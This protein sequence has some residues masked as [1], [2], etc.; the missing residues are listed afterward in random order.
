MSHASHDLVTLLEQSLQVDCLRAGRTRAKLSPKWVHVPFTIIGQSIDS[1]VQFRT[2]PHGTIVIEKGEGYLLRGGVR[3]FED[4]GHQPAGLFQWAHYRFTLLGDMDLLDFLDLPVRLP[5]P[6]AH[7]VRQLNES[8]CSLLEDQTSP[9]LLRAM[10]RR[11]ICSRMLALVMSL[12]TLSEDPE[13]GLMRL[14]RLIPALKLMNAE[15]THPIL[16]DELASAC[17]LSP[18]RFHALFAQATGQSPLAYLTAIRLKR[19]QQLLVTTS[20]PI[21]QIASQVGFGDAFHFSRTFQKHV[22]QS[23]RDYRKQGKTAMTQ[24]SPTRP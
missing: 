19:A 1:K 24:A 15:I 14:A 6:V 23:P 16:R 8:M 3:F 12:A 10:R 9:A 7:E 13:H 5:T 2:D 21:N 18:S 22:G 11:E 20:Q 4:M 17:H